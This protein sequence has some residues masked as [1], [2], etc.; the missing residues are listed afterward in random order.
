M[1]QARRA[2]DLSG[3]CCLTSLPAVAVQGVVAD[4]SGA[5]MVAT[6]DALQG[7]GT[8]GLLSLAAANWSASG[9][10]LRSTR[11]PIWQASG[12][13]RPRRAPLAVAPGP[14]PR[15]WR[16]S[17]NGR[18]GEIRAGHPAVQRAPA[19]ARSGGGVIDVLSAALLLAGGAVRRAGRSRLRLASLLY[20]HNL[21]RDKLC[22]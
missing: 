1:E 7:G 17:K 11:K 14:L 22:L 13:L 8:P 16:P 4:R 5:P 19:Q 9:S 6:A 2:A 12:G 3:A 20:K 10:G 18:S 15:E 21:Y